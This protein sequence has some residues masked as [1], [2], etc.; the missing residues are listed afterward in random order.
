MQRE[1]AANTGRREFLTVIAPACAITC[2]GFK[3]AY[4]QEGAK[5]STSGDSAA[6]ESHRFDTEFPDKLTYRQYYRV[7]YGEAID[8]AKSL[9]EEMGRE[10][11][12]GFLKRY[13]S[14]VMGDYG[15]SQATRT[16]DHSLR[17][18]TELFRNFDNYRNRLAM[19][20]VED[21][22]RAFELKVT[23]CIWASTFREADAGELGYA[24][25]CHG[26]YAWAES[27]NPMIKL[28]RDKTLMQGDAIC[29]H[30]YVWK[31]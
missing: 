6:G 15:K 31:G 10:K 9:Q 4:A 25:V 22:D 28:E 18:Y 1:L 14:R 20:I 16:E 23:K 17:Q 12:V 3:L 21:T 2:L 26:D 11:A 7:R 8:L 13:A 30:R 5:A 19:E 24:M 27:F 29:N